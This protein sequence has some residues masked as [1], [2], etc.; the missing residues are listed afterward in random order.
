MSNYLLL[1]AFMNCLT[2][3]ILGVDKWVRYNGSNLGSSPEN[4][5]LELGSH[6][7]ETLL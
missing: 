3:N 5:R 6:K 1:G 4:G 2:T 7:K